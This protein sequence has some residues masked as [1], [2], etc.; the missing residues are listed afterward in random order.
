MDKLDT[1][2][3]RIEHLRTKEKVTQA[4]LAVSIGVKRETIHQWESGTRDLKTGAIIK[5]AQYFK[6]SADWLLGLSDVKSSD[7]DMQRLHLET[8]LSEDAIHALKVWHN[9]VTTASTVSYT[10]TT[11]IATVNLLL[12]SKH[13]NDAIEAI[14]DFMSFQIP[15]DTVKIM[16]WD[17]KH[18]ARGATIS[19]KAVENQLFPIVEHNLSQLK[20]YARSSGIYAEAEIHAWKQFTKK[21]KELA[22]GI[23]ER[24]RLMKGGAD[25]GKH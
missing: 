23:T 1:M 14:H 7:S 17:N 8:G 10:M 4:E 5:L 18:G 15:V 6:V 2:G 3:K 22:E 19:S 21:L 12:G 24:K 11:I 9:G 20:E 16:P 13:G 25:D